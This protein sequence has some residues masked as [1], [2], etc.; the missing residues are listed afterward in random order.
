MLLILCAVLVVAWLIG[1]AGF[2]IAAGVIH[3]LL[4]VSVAVL[5]LHYADRRRT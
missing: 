3:L 5:V 4:F 1:W 2:H